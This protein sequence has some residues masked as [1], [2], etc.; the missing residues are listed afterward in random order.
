MKNPDVVVIGS[1]V[2]G[3][4]V[5]YSLARAGVRVLMLE[6]GPRLPV[7]AENAD[8]EAV[9]VQRR[10]RAQEVW[11][12]E[13]GRRFAPGQYYFVGG[14]TKFYGTAM[15]RFREA[16]FAETVYRD[17]VSPAWPVSYAELEPWYARAEQ[18]FG[19]HGRAGDDPCEPW[20]SSPFPHPP[21]PHEPLIEG[22]ARRMADLGLKPFHMPSA[23]DFHAGGQCVRCRT[24]DAFPCRYGAK[25]DA[26]T[27]LLSPLQSLPNFEL[28]SDSRVLRLITDERGRNIVG[29]EVARHGHTV[30]VEAPVFVLSAGA[31]N[32]ALLLQ[33]SADSRNPDGLANSSGCVGRYYMNHNTTGMMALMPWSINDTRF[34]KT[35]SVN[36]F[37]FGTEDDSEPLGNLQMLGNIQEPMIHASYPSIPR[38]IGR[39]IARHSVDM[40]VMSEDLPHAESTVRPLAGDR[41]ELCWRRTNGAVH[42]RFVKRTRGLLRRLGAAAVLAHPFGVETPSHQCGTVRMGLDPAKAALDAW[43]RTYDHPNLYVVDA[44]CFPSSA[45]LNPALT[46]AA[47]ALRASAR[48]ALDWR[49]G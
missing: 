18:L 26:E 8:A 38:W 10:Y 21:V 39:A 37:Y 42:Q 29:A 44:S 24:C 5:A 32:S 33:R 16:D 19:V 15:F 2:G 7:E 46:I 14:H 6:R 20:R 45:A 11:Q 12:T 41:V 34:Q 9:F 30:R 47:L 35:L 48:L 23:I 40:L 1:G 3:G 13:T 22:L 36:D 4:A 43:C 17:G 25:G 49:L 27:R 31:I 28:W